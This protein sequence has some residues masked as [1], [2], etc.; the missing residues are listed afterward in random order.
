MFGRIV[1][2]LVN[3]VQRASKHEVLCIFS[4]SARNKENSHLL[5]N[6][7]KVEEDDFLN[8]NNWHLCFLLIANFQIPIKPERCL[9]NSDGRP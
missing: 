6:I 2:E 3:K 4:V 1:L 8:P 7:E 5:Q 9:A